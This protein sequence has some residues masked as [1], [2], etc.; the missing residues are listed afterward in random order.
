MYFL[1]QNPL[2]REDMT[3]DLLFYCEVETIYL[4]MRARQNEEN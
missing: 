3:I 1:L 4:H 2:D